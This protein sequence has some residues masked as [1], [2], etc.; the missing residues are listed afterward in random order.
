MKDKKTSSILGQYH[1]QALHNF[2]TWL[3]MYNA[4]GVV[5]IALIC[6]DHCLCRFGPVFRIGQDVS[7]AL[8][9][10]GAGG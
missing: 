9:P 8:N 6:F 10:K 3:V 2:Y 1:C 5:I 7:F 4:A